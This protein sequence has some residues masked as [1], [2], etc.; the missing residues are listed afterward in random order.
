M[1]LLL[2]FALF[3]A[4][5]VSKH[6]SAQTAV[7]FSQP[8]P[9]SEYHK[10][11][12]QGFSTNYFKPDD[13]LEKD[14]SYDPKHIQDVY[15]RGFRNL[16][17]R[18]RPDSY[19]KQYDSSNFTRFL[20]KLEE[21]VDKCIEVGVAPIISWSNHQAEAYATEEERRLY[22][23]W[24][25]KVAKRLQDK[26]YHLAFNLFTELGRDVC[27]SDCSQSLRTNINKYNDWT[28]A[29]VR[30]IRNAGGKN[31]ERILILGAPEKTSEN[32]DNINSRI[33]ENDPYMLV[34]WHFYAAGPNKRYITIKKT[35][36]RRKSP[37]YWTGNGEDEERQVL[38][39]FIKL[40]EDF[41]KERGLLTYFGAWMPRDNK[42]GQLNQE[43]VITFARFFVNELK[44]NKIPWS[45]NVL[46][47]Y[48]DTRKSE[49]IRGVQS[50]PRGKVFAVELEMDKV[51][52]EIVDAMNN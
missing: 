28:N 4:S 2:C 45:L 1:H 21:V 36:K 7:D 23:Y 15:D 29:V 47:D 26:N 18:C 10:I 8:V 3:A 31:A 39:D 43:E 25:E 44:I 34:E 20:D 16:R 9:A 35:E 17:L 38:K 22:L 13:Q 6:A 33:Y 40:A 11:I 52:D 5:I 46:D 19:N 48:Y 32:L 30:T 49:W 27:K 51:L 37:R 50:L 14:F 42:G 12:K 41:T 24:W